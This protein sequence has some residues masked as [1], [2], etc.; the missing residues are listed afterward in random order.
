MTRNR[1]RNWYKV[2]VALLFLGP[3]WSMQAQPE[4]FALLRGA[5]ILLLDG[6]GHEL[7]KL[8]SDRRPKGNLL[9]AVG[10]QRLAYQVK[11][12]DGAKGRLVI[13]DLKGTVL[14]EISLQPVTEP[15]SF[16]FRYIEDVT[17]LTARTVRVHGS[18]NNW[19][20]GVYD[21]DVDSGEEIG[22]LMSG[23]CRDFVSSPDGKHVA[24]I[25]TTSG[26]PDEQRDDSVEID[27]EHLVYRGPGDVLNVVTGPVWSDDSRRV[28]FVHKN[29]RTGEAALAFLSIDGKSG[30]VPLP[31][32]FGKGASL[33][34]LGDD[35]AVRD[36]TEMLAVSQRKKTTVRAAA[37]MVAKIEHAKSAE[38]RKQESLRSLATLR[39]KFGA[40][41]C[42]ALPE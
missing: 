35:V 33:T 22:G 28:A 39:Q 21:V 18:I 25:G 23:Q 8:T 24:Y 31:G 19:N 38:R 3:A 9:W 5:E 6:E 14:K 37:A 17:W 12:D 7:S 1:T 27:S 30:R 13:I 41:E 20:C 26:G 10:G 16:Q 2:S 34:W 36:E 4:K 32:H 15:P 40:T 29:A 42:V 11:A